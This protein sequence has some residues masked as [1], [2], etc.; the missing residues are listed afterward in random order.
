MR[1]AG[2]VSGYLIPTTACLLVSVGFATLFLAS[3]LRQSLPRVGSGPAAQVLW[4]LL[5]S[6]IGLLG[7]TGLYWLIAHHRDFEVRVLMAIVVAP[8]SAIV[9][10][11][12]SQTILMAVAKMVSSFVVSLAVLASL[13]T[14]IFSA[15][16]ILSDAL[17]TRVRNL[18]FV[19]YGALLGAF[20]SL[21]LPTV[22]LVVLLVTV[23]L[24]D[25]LLLNHRW[26][27]PLIRD[28][29]RSR[30]AASRFGYV[31]ASVEVGIGELI[32]Y[33]FLPAHVGAY[34]ATPLLL[35]TLAM[36]GLGV[37]VNLWALNR[38]RYLPGLPAPLLLGVTPLLLSL[39]G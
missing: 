32:F 14:A 8:T 6:A 23:A 16:F 20:I 25:L 7:V 11:V 1:K 38:R 22:S 39:L 30:S 10:I 24:Y 33:A 19:A 13:F 35:L 5:M 4:T 31:G 26:I 37:L 9:V 34:Y 36:I 17:S 3:G 12:L 21:L 2:L 28:L 27:L 29:S 15:I 18:L